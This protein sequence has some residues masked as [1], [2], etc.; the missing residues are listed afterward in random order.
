MKT[1]SL[2]YK[3]LLQEPQLILELAGLDQAGGESYQFRSEE[4]K[5]TAFRLDGVL[6]PPVD[7]I[8]LPLI[9]V[10]VQFQPD[11]TFYSRFFC[12][13]FFYLHQNQPVNPWHAV[14][15]YPTR[16]T[17][18][19]G[20][21]HYSVLLQ[22]PQVH[23][24]YLEDLVDKPS[25]NARVRLLQLIVEDAD[26]APMAAKLLI[27]EIENGK[28]V[29][30]NKA[31]IL[32]MIETILVYKFPTLGREE[33]K[34]M[35]GYNDISLKQTQFYREVF[36]EGEQEGEQ[37]GILKG[38]QKGLQKGMQKGMLKGEEKMKLEVARRLLK[39]GMSV[40]EVAEITGISAEILSVL[41]DTE[42]ESA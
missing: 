34:K 38:M 18:T 2:F 6:S 19:S 24:L 26:R 27:E 30:D 25:L 29:V 12:E 42:I 4:I 36:A 31:E 21:R 17:E 37:K 9:F 40:V 16:K 3:L 33:V 41:C 11:R 8:K 14:V 1:D 5:Q 39:K 35:L 32:E 10:E 22:C 28:L 20:D 15:I 7:N 13:I 23:R